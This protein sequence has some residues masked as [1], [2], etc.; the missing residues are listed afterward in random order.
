[1]NDRKC[2]APSWT[3]SQNTGRTQGPAGHPAGEPTSSMALSISCTPP[4][5][6]PADSKFLLT[7]LVAA[8]SQAILQQTR[9][10]ANTR[11]R[12]TNNS[13]PLNGFCRM[14]AALSAEIGG[15]A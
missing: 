9:A 14:A 4:E 15:T 5:G 10:C 2:Q 3:A 11:R 8:T 6:V 7:G 1:M 13:D 12:V